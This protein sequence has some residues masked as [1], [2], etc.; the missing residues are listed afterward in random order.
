MTAPVGHE[1]PVWVK[2]AQAMTNL[3]SMPAQII[4][5]LVPTDT[6]REVKVLDVAAGHGLFGINF[7]QRNPNVK[8]TALDWP[9]VLEIAKGNAA[10][11]GVAG[12]YSLKPGSAFDVDFGSGYDVVLLTNFLHHF[13]VPTNEVLIRKV[14]A[15]L[16]DGG[17]AVT[18]EFVPNPDRVSPPGAAGFS[19]V[20]LGST[21]GGDAYTF[22]ELDGM[23]KRCGFARSEIHPVMEGMSSV[24]VSYK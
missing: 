6:S 4:S 8:V 5:Q 24:V 19:L 22:E 7:A 21:P 9:S 16:A 13:D 1:N 20:M 3:M 18:L 10:A 11:A 17:R 2:F 23:F 12:Q 15:A 14:H